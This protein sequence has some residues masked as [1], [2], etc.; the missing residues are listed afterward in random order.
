MDAREIIEKLGLVPLLHEGGYYRESYRSPELV[1]KLPPRYTSARLY[2]SAI[3]YLLTSDDACFSAMHRLKTDE[4]YHFYLGD[5]AEML[6]LHEN[7]R[8]ERVILG[9]DL[10][11]GQH[12][13]YVVSR[14]VWQGSRVRPGG[15][16]SLMGTTMAPGFSPDDFELGDRERL[17]ARYPAESG[18]ITS[19]THPRSR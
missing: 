15:K 4:V 6:L 17:L 16:W 8:A 13:Q 10:V 3:Y 19:L 2:G 11:A 5:P 18:L 7:G 1:E 9:Q 12:V 14:D